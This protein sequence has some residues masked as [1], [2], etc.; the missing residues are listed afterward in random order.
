VKVVLLPEARVE[1]REATEWYA[2]RSTDVARRFVAA[3]QHTKGLIAEAP[4]RWAEVEPGVRR[5]LFEKFPYALLYVVE[6]RQVVVLV[7]KHHKRHPDD[8]KSRGR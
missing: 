4:E 1:L 7:V 3:Y 8:W 6:E 2:S 5:V